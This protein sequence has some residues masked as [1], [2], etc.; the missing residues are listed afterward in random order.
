MKLKDLK[1]SWKEIEKKYP[2]GITQLFSN[3]VLELKPV[4]TCCTLIVV[5]SFSDSTAEYFITPQGIKYSS[6]IDLLLVTHNENTPVLNNREFIS[7]C[8]NS[9]ASKL[10]MVDNGFHIGIRYRFNCELPDFALKCQSLGYHFDRHPLVLYSGYQINL[11]RS[12]IV[13]TDGH[14]A[15]NVCSKLW[16]ILRGLDFSPSSKLWGYY[17][18][19][20]SRAKACIRSTLEYSNSKLGTSYYIKGLNTHFTP[21]EM[22]PRELIHLVSYSHTMISGVVSNNPDL[23]IAAS[24]DEEFDF[25]RVSNGQPLMLLK[26]LCLMIDLVAKSMVQKT[27]KDEMLL[28]CQYARMFNLCSDCTYECQVS[29]EKVYYRI[30]YKLAEK[31]MILSPLFNRDRGPQFLSSLNFG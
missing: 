25:F 14:S 30:R 4:I 17:S 28:L 8:L 5:G 13:Y 11:G 16:A 24:K 1:S 19:V 12:D 23:C 9:L 21:I 6:D 15:E 22:L 3:I 31:R 26:I 20:V 7:A 29:A 10:P 18:R 27:T 2:T